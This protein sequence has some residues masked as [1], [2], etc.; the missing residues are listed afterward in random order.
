MIKGE[1][2]PHEKKVFSLFEPWTEWIQ[3]GK[4]GNKVE[5]GLRVSVCSDQYGFILRQRVIEKEQ[6]VDVAVIIAES[7]LE[8]YGNIDSISYDKGFWSKTNFQGIAEK[9]SQAVMPKKGKLN[10]TEREREGSKEFRRLRNKH[11]AI[12]SDINAIEHHGLDRCPDRGIDHF[13]V[14]T[15]LGILSCNLHRLGNA[16]LDRDR[17][18]R[19]V[20]K[21]CER[22]AA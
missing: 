20:L 9:I 13:R 15:A 22:K 10:H 12:E 19:E 3:K 5:L 11:S 18:E 1:H 2:I 21:C 14:F 17:S 8:N 7:V 4:A 6:D 16:L